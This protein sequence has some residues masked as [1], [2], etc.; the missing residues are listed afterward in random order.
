MKNR[1]KFLRAQHNLTQEQLAQK[2]GI[3]RPALSDIETGKRMPGGKVVIRIAN[4]FGVPAE[5]IFFEEDVIQEE[6]NAI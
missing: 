6:H 1:I 5:Q 2:I 4:V 3:T